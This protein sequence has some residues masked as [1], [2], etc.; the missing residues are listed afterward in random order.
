M[1]EGTRGWCLS[2]ASGVRALEVGCVETECILNLLVVS[3]HVQLCKQ[4]VENALAV[5]AGLS[6]EKVKHTSH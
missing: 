3:A 5:R 4:P 2:D 1:F 6:L